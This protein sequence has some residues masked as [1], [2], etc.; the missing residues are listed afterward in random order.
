MC[1]ICALR[2]LQ[3]SIMSRM[4]TH[5]VS[6]LKRDLVQFV[7]GMKPFIRF[8]VFPNIAD[9][10][11]KCLHLV[12]KKK[13]PRALYPFQNTCMLLYI[14]CLKTPV[15]LE[16]SASVAAEWKPCPAN[17]HHTA[18]GRAEYNLLRHLLV[19]LVSHHSTT[20]YLVVIH[21]VRFVWPSGVK[22]TMS[23]TYL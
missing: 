13:R 1:V 15:T 3:R 7:H 14:H 17:L 19:I 5:I 20:P 23:V 10:T 18:Y 4:L 11:P 2:I 12:K 21:T 22:T 8:G 9:C 6:N 16:V